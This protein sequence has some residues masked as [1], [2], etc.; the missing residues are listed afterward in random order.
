MTIFTYC[1]VR[2]PFFVALAVMVSGLFILKFS[3]ANNY[4]ACTEK[5]GQSVIT[6]KNIYSSFTKK[7]FTD[8]K[9]YQW[10]SE[11]KA[12]TAIKSNTFSNVEKMT[13]PSGKYSLN[14]SDIKIK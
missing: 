3:S 9:I 10:T 4:T 8:V 12:L 13:P 5:Q 11:I 6:L 2:K 1:P 7:S 14:V